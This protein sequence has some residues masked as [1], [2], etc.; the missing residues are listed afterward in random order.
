[1]DTVVA[2]VA[3]TAEE[4]SR[5]LMYR[6]DVPDGTGMLFV[7]DRPDVQSFWMENTYVP[8]DIAFMDASFRVVDIQQMEAEST[9]IH[10]SAAPAM[11]ALEVR[12]G[13]LEEQGIEVGD[14]AEI[15]FGR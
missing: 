15:V 7:F 11:F 14:V 8:L 5:G 4:R 1:A 12:L 6:D 10:E 9:D 3:R 2:E 13:W